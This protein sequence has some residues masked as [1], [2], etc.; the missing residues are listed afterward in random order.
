MTLYLVHC[1]WHLEAIC[2]L[3]NLVKGSP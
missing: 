3:E 1:L 2:D